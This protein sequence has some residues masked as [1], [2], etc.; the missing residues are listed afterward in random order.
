MEDVVP[1]LKMLQFYLG[2]AVPTAARGGRVG[3][4]GK[5]P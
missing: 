3:R 5:E 4:E 1:A 2:E